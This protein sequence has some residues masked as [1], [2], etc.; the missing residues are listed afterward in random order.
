MSA[1]HHKL[2][3]SLGRMSGQMVAVT[4]VLV[5]GEMTYVSM[6]SAYASLEAAWNDYHAAYRFA[7]V[8]AQVK[9]APE[10]LRGSLAAI[11]GVAGV[12]TRI[13]RDVIL[14]IPGLEEPA[15]ARLVSIPES[16]MPML[17]DVFVRRGRYL[18][19]GRRNEVLISEALAGANQLDLGS[20][21]DAVINGKW[22]RLVIVGIALSPEY[23][24]EVKAGDI[25]PDNRRFGVLWMSRE[26]M[27]AA[28]DMKEAFND[29]SLSL[30]HGA[31]ESE[32][33]ARVDQQLERFGGL[34]AYGRSDH[35]SYR[36]ITDEL[37]ELRT[38]G[39]VLPGLFLA[40]VA[41]LLHI[42]MTRLIGTE[43]GQI[44]VLKS[45]G[46]TKLEI[47]GHYLTFAF[48]AVL[49]GAVLG[50]VG[51][52]YG[53]SFFTGIY[54]RYFHFP[55]L[56]L[57]IEPDIVLAAVLSGVGAAC[58]GALAAVR[59]AVS[60][61]PAEAMRPEAPAN[62]RAGVLERSGMLRFLSPATR[63]ISRNMARRPWKTI[64]TAA[65]MAMAV[66]ILLVGRYTFDAVQNV[67]DL[68]FRVLQ[69][70]DVTVAFQEPREADVRYALAR[71]PG[72]LLVDP[73]RSVPVRLR[74]GHRT[75]RTVIQGVAPESSLRPLLDAKLSPVSLPP[76]GIVLNSHLGELMGAYP[77]Q[78]IT[79]EILEGTRPKREVTVAGWV[80]EPIGLGAYMDHDALRRLMR[81]T[82]TVSGAYLRVD[83][84]QAHQLY[85]ILKRMP[86][87]SAVSVKETTLASFWKS[88]GETIWISTL[89]LV[90]FAGVIAAGIVYN[91]ARI[92]LSE[93][94]H[95]LASLRILGYTRPEIGRILLG[96]QAILTLAAIPTGFFTGYWI[97]RLTS[98]AFQR[99]L[100]RL[101]FVLAPV[102]Y[103]YAACIVSAAA[104]LSGAA[105]IHRLARMDLTA[106]LKSRE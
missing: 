27:E 89:M 4:A 105:V 15:T 98:L 69:R 36:F 71:L 94:G 18:E 65:G 63:M 3:R 91:S 102:S 59:K 96:E 31:S 95:E 6:N 41:F 67:V 47:A 2:F 16:R 73:F 80:D 11:S 92:A 42:L 84:S 44:A 103:V 106:V 37:A 75:R 61:A 58:L 87:V 60:L 68:E 72:V 81:E 28:F 45:F 51:G 55:D 101:P 104:V 9:R 100:F 76:G 23:L 29:V 70:Q 50:I 88:Y 43:R 99:E 22:E 34:G 39:T 62:F 74:L 40:V 46:Y 82:E 97:S 12:D 10:S 26:A 90:T 30:T 25:F 21:I 85:A 13:V 32:V 1:L 86:S 57:R 52:L 17:N 64:T 20:H 53:G 83:A 54:A 33:I 35:L 56:H 78:S 24:Y 48:L 14:D 66:S 49:P 38:M 5:C 19:A 7:N 79:V 77:G 8:F 93:R